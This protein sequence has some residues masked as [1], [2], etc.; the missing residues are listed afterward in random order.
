MRNSHVCGGGAA[1]QVRRD[2]AR[3]A[4]LDARLPPL[5]IEELRCFDVDASKDL[6]SLGDENG[7]ECGRDQ[8]RGG[9]R[10][11]DATRVRVRA[12]QD[13]TLVSVAGGLGDA[14]VDNVVRETAANAFARILVEVLDVCRAV[15]I[16]HD[17][18]V[19]V[20]MCARRN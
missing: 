5:T 3:K 9:T 1:P 16:V 8:I 19:R 4:R 13:N 10:C 12:S 20:C 2:A 15:R 14:A 6:A 17:D 18:A 11:P 7:T